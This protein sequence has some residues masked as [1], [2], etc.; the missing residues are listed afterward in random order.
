MVFSRKLDGFQICGAVSTRMTQI[1]R[2]SRKDLAIR[3]FP[4]TVR[5]D[6]CRSIRDFR[7]QEFP[8]LEKAIDVVLIH[9][10][11]VKMIIYTA[12]MFCAQRPTVT[13]CEESSVGRFI[14]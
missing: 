10:D 9:L 6:R 7:V 11:V 3:A 1:G 2:I 8:V 12:L 14:R 5:Q 4:G 13:G